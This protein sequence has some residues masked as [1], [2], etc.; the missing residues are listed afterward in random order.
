MRNEVLEQAS[1]LREEILSNI[2]LFQISFSNIALKTSM[3]AR[4]LDDFI[5]QLKMKLIVIFIKV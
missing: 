3:L 4:P 1:L 2:E 5:F